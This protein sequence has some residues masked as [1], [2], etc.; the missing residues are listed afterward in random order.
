[1]AGGA[2]TV[3]GVIKLAIRS[4]D[5]DSEA[6]TLAVIGGIGWLGLQGRF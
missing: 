2:A 6:P 4:S 3:A 5:S 1:V